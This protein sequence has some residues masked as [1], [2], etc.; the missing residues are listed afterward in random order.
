MVS[1]QLPEGFEA[2]YED[3]VLTVTDGDNEVTKKMEHALIEVEVS[4]DEVVFTAL[5]SKRNVE[6]ITG[7][8]KSHVE[9]MVEGL[10][11]AHVYEL[12]GVYA[13]FPMTIKQQG[14]E[15][16]LQNFMGERKDRVIDVMEGVDVEVDGDDL[17]L[18]GHD[19]DAVAQTAARIEQ[20]CHKGDRDPRSFQDG[21]YITKRGKKQ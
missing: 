3:G 4:D 20:A 15:I 6:S 17:K 1:A 10:E 7:T 5:T 19:K 14:D 21:V 8:F 16:H 2:S 11:E 13:H 9:N 12:S 18:T